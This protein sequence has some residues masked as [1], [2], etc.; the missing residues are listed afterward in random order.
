[1]KII[2]YLFYLSPEKIDRL[3]VEIYKEKNKI[4]EFLAQ[5]EIDIS[6]K[7]YPVVRYDSRHGFAHRD[8][9]Y[10]RWFKRKRTIIV[11]GL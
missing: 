7:W 11:A 8:L 9:L 6:E 5:Y 2:E 1:M 4:L 10:P 3:R